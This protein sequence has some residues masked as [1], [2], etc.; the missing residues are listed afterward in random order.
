MHTQ[1]IDA[2]LE[3]SHER[4]VAEMK[5]SERMQKLLDY[6][7]VLHEG[8]VDPVVGEWIG[9]VAELESENAAFKRENERFRSAVEHEAIALDV[10]IEYNTLTP[11]YVSVTIERMRAL[12][13]A[14]NATD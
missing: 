3:A 6:Q 14:N 10:A 2:L 12:L 1:P 9:E 5:L 8:N 7:T 13:E 4:K 11:Q